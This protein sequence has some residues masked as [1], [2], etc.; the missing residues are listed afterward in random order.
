M[1]VAEKRGCRPVPTSFPGPSCL[2]RTS[3][4]GVMF[5][6]DNDFNGHPGGGT[7]ERLQ[8]RP[9]DPGSLMPNRLTAEHGRSVHVR[10]EAPGFPDTRRVP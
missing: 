4:E 1:A 9:P 8:P 6:A 5:A 10:S 3:A 7:L 2:K